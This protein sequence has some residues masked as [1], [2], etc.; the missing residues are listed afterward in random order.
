M[1]V[2]EFRCSMGTTTKMTILINNQSI[3][4]IVFRKNLNEITGHDPEFLNL[5]DDN[6]LKFLKRLENP[7]IDRYLDCYE[8]KNLKEISLEEY[9]LKNKNR[10]DDVRILF[11]LF[12]NCII[13]NVIY[14]KI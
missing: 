6:V 1:K 12:N 14:R 7:Q 8:H 5:T 3:I 13:I 2:S 10:Q 9:T 4:H 11:K